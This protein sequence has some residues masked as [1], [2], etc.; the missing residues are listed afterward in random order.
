VKPLDAAHNAAAAAGEPLALLTSADAIA[1]L[2]SSRQLPKS[3]RKWEQVVFV[4]LG[5]GLL[6]PQRR[7]RLETAHRAGVRVPA[8]VPH[9]LD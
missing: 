9:L 8:C 3:H 7:F 1:L 6:L 4:R 2:T 5:L